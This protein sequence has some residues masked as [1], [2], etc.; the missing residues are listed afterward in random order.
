MNHEKVR[1]KTIPNYFIFTEKELISL[2]L[3]IMLDIIEYMA[4]ILTM[5]VVG[6]FFDL[7]GIVACVIMFGWI[8]LVSL[9][10]LIPGA[11]ILPVFI[12]TW[13]IWYLYNQRKK[14][15]TLQTKWT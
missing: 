14:E 11:D 12:V 2:V 6:D 1:S 13:L 5:P 15:R 7:I 3:C 8:G 4:I 9:I 10:E